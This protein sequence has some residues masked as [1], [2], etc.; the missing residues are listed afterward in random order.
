MREMFGRFKTTM[1]TMTT[2]STIRLV[3]QRTV[4]YHP[5]PPFF[6]LVLSIGGAAGLAR[7]AA[8]MFAKGGGTFPNHAQQIVDTING[9]PSDTGK[10][11]LRQC[12]MTSLEDQAALFEAAM[13]R[14]GGV[15]AVVSPPLF[16]MY[17]VERY[18]FLTP[19]R[20]ARIVGHWR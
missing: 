12:D 1:R 16:R 8:W 17:V 15:N 10:A 13:M 6:T 7:H 3:S 11:C 19:A 14:F 4:L 20:R 9:L 2:R 18:W 5:F